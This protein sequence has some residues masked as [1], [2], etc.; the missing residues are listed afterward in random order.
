MILVLDIFFNWAK[1]RFS[2]NLISSIR[3][4]NS[5]WVHD[6]LVIQENF[7]KYYVDLFCPTYGNQNWDEYQSN[8]SSL[9]DCIQ[10]KISEEDCLMLARPFTAADVR[11]AVFQMGPTKSPGR[12]EFPHFFI[13]NADISSSM[14]LLQRHFLFLIRV[15]YLRR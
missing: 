1:G 13:R 6:I 2:R 15:I 14:M 4:T 10:N 12:M 7:R 5:E 8:H 11:K 9:F 3:L